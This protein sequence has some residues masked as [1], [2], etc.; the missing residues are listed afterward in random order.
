MAKLPLLA[1]AALAFNVCTNAATVP[2]NSTTEYILM[3]GAK[4]KTPDAYLCTAYHVEEI[5]NYIYKFEAVAN[6]STAH[7]M[8]LYGCD[9]E[10][11]SSDPIWNCPA[12]CKSSQATI[13][14]AWAKN[15]P[16]TVL[17]EGV[18][19]RI[20]TTIK[21][22]VLQVHYARSFQEE[23]PAD[24]SGIKI[25]I[26]KQ[27]P[28][29]VAGIYILMAGYFSIPSGKKSYPVDVSCSFNEEKS[30]FPFAYR[31][32]A[33]GLGR[34]ITGY[35][36]NGSHHEIGKGN[37]QW[38]QAFYSTQNKIEV[39]KGDK[40]AARCTYDSTSMTHPV[41]VGSTGSDEMCNFY[42]MFYTDSSVVNPYGQC[43]GDFEPLVT[44]QN[45]PKDVS[46]P[47]P[48]N[49][50]LE[51]EAK[52]H[53]HHG[54][55]TAS[56]HNPSEDVESDPIADSQTEDILMRGAKPEK[57]DAYLCTAYPLTDQEYYIYKF[58]ALANASTA[59]HMLLYGCDG[60]PASKDQI[61]NCPAMC[62]GKQ[63]TIL[64]AWAKNAPPTILPKGVGLRIGSSTSIKTLVLQ[65]HYARSFEDSEAPDH[66]GIMIHT[67]HKKQKFVAGIFLL[68]S[69]SFS[70]PEGNSSYP[71]DIS[72]KFDQE[73]SIFPFAYR[74]HAH[75][76]GRVITGYQKN[77]TYHQIGKGNPQWPQAFYP[78]KDVIEVKPGDYLAARCTYDSTS[79]SHPV[80]VGA[81]GNDEMCNFYIMFYTD[82]SVLEPYGDCSYDEYPDL[83]GQNFPK[84]VSMP[85]PPNPD[86]E[87]EAKG[88]HHHGGMSGSSHGSSDHVDAPEDGGNT[89]TDS[90]IEHILMRG[91][92]PSKPDAYLCASYVPSE[93][94]YFIYKFEAMAQASTA[95]HMLLYGC[96]GE[97]FS[98]QQ[99]WNCPLMC[100]DQQATILF[101]WAKNA[102]PT[103]LPKDVGLRI[104]S[105]TSIKTLV[106]QVHYARSFTE[107]E[108]PDYSGITLFS[109]H[110]KPKFV[111]GIYF[112]MSP[113][114]NIPP[115]ETSYPIDVS[116]KFGAEK[117][118]VPFA[119]RTHAHGLGRVITGYQHNG[120]Y[121]EIGKGNPQWPQAFYPVKDLIE[122]KPGDAL[123]ARC[124]YDSTTMAH[125]VSVGSTGNDEMCNFYIMFYTDSSVINPY[126]Q[127]A[128]NHLP[129]VTG[130]NFPPDVSVPLPPNPE[131]E[132]V[133][134]GTH[135]HGGMSGS[136]PHGDGTGEGSGI[137]DSNIQEILMRGAKPK[138][139]DAYLCTAYPVFDE[140]SYIYKFEAL[141]NASVAHHILL[142]GCEG[143][144]YS[145]EAIWNCPAMCKS[146]EGIIL[147]AWAKNAPPTVLPKDVGLRI[148]STTI[149][150]TLVLQ[151]HYAKSFSDEE[152]PDHSGIK[153]YTTQTKQ[154]F[155]AGVYFMA[156]MFEIPSGFPAYPVDVSCMFDKQ[157]SIFPFAYRTHAHALGRVITGYQYNGSYHEIGKGNPQWPQA[158][159]PVKDKIEVKPGE[160]LAA[161]CT[162]DSTSMT[163]SVKVGSTG[164]D[165]MC[166]FYIMFYT[167]SSVLDPYGKCLGNLA[168]E[169]TG[170]NFPKDVSV[171]LPPNPELEEEAKGQHP[172]HHRGMKAKLRKH[173]RE[174]HRPS[175]R[176]RIRQKKLRHFDYDYHDWS[177]AHNSR[178]K[179]QAHEYYDDYAAN[180][181]REK[182]LYGT[183]NAAEEGL[184]RNRNKEFEAIN[185]E[186][187]HFP[188]KNPPGKFIQT[189][190]PPDQPLAPAQQQHTVA[191]ANPQNSAPRKLAP[192]GVGA[193][194]QQA[195]R[196]AVKVHSSIHFDH[197]LIFNS[198]WPEQK[199][200]LGQIGGVAADRD[201]NV[202]I[203]H[204]G[205]RTWT[206]QS[207]SYDNNFQYQDSPIPEEVIVILDSAGRLVRKFGAG[208]Y[209][210]PHGIEVD[211]QGN[212][213][214]TDVA[215]HQVFKIPAGETKPTLTLGHRFQHSENLTC[216]CKPTDV[217]VVSNGDFFVSDGYCNSR[218]LKFSKDGQ[219]LKAF[220]QRNLGFSPAPPVGVF[221]IPHSITVSE[222]NNLVCVADRENGRVQ[223]FDLDG[224]FK[225]MIKHPQFGPRLFAIE[226]C[227]EHGG[228]LYA[229]N[230]PAYDGP[231]DFS[232]QGF[233]MDINTGD[234]LEMWNVP[235]HLKN[236]HDVCVHPASHSV[237]IGELNPTAVWKLSRL[238][239]AQPVRPVV[240]Q[241]ESTQAHS[242]EAKLSSD[243]ISNLGV[244]STYS[245]GSSDSSSDFTPSVIIGILLVIPVI[246]LLVITL[247]VRAHH[248]GKL[249]CYGH[250]NKPRVFNL[251]GIMGNSHKGFDPLSTEES[252][253]EGDP[254]DSDHKE[255]LA[256]KRIKSKA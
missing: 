155:V 97:P 203:F 168:P 243:I 23:E 162:Y 254:D 78:V 152:A 149:I 3:K 240:I 114:F 176:Y 116:C 30:I 246:L 63:A 247:L 4:P 66:S 74:T 179:R 122:V 251:Q 53:Q 140:E 8:L 90:K 232:V 237:Y 197:N 227:P 115:G 135:H 29:Y 158:F 37:P 170:D 150:K 70:I 161:R 193:A 61:W 127:C 225:H 250:G 226:Q 147:F 58:E 85:L 26:T 40:L 50:D 206:A 84:D 95:H 2:P 98:D 9:G 60:E 10:P 51:E 56:S 256:P 220:G 5:K 96:D 214:L 195:S 235:E 204:R 201:G 126:G 238:S 252:D 68:M 21:T 80:S 163:S 228:I 199:V 57:S 101:A 208:Q 210:M 69:T 20:G 81:T 236:P 198:T 55:M 180:D 62:D 107:S 213:W 99:I 202:Y 224:N 110:T 76:L 36:F 189:Q 244:N 103:V 186:L 113:M 194:G 133:A 48:P 14:F 44:G 190:Q 91:A 100:K 130:R 165:E 27:K 207:F 183:A 212:L 159:Y 87:E 45:F 137:M 71:V 231:S 192:P 144:P 166:N 234:L 139:P 146:T 17:P 64:F 65:V 222:E 83:T 7:H 121:H 216:F 111:A 141:A 86:L 19:L 102:P 93:E 230:G 117:S 73:K 119:Y 11:Y 32:H 38:P 209:F 16:P 105:R 59:H 1:L 242:G 182:G 125:A 249:K 39:K 187:R 177:Q 164:N 92:K 24:H 33:H 120:S 229:V 41:S 138:T 79:M 6:A 67:T 215:L 151:V 153:I 75:G 196:E 128:G 31:T 15:A 241:E 169:L 13:L 22:L 123:A 94:E 154:P 54:V 109:T 134:K 52:G 188:R 174:N 43:V 143:E 157:K 145:N 221:D 239:P 18:G 49:P 34:V 108:P 89:I 172:Q 12:M 28:Q 129:D 173:H 42:I 35:Q 211:N 47:L 156:S 223:C 248:S 136:D 233:T 160:Y 205:S 25:Y 124:T 148:G 185:Q 178:H 175:H 184:S 167:D 218:V 219:L 72:C 112:L 200:E 118:I 104:G 255:Y 245:D 106:L 253:H 181:L 131:L 77:E 82:S 46:D 132:E 191:A 171:P 88:N 142:Y 217:A